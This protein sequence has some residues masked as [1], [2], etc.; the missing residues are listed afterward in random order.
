MT[1]EKRTER[2]DGGVGGTATERDN[3]ASPKQAPQ[4]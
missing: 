4:G 2:K 1:I 3:V